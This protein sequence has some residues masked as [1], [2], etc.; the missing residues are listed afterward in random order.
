M[1]ITLGISA[2]VNLSAF[3]S[4]RDAYW[5]RR[6]RHCLVTLELMS[7][8]YEIT[9]TNRILQYSIYEWSPVATW[10]FS[11][12]DFVKYLD[13]SETIYYMVRAQA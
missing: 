12:C 4:E 10:L 5:L 9:K 7:W 11:L 2:A 13:S 1:V 8:V 3:R 6:S